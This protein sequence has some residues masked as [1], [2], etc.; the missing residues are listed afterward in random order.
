MTS[1]LLTALVLLFSLAAGAAVGVWS[2]DP[3][4]DRLA[5]RQQAQIGPWRVDMSLASQEAGPY[6]RAYTAREAIWA[7]SKEDALYLLALDDSEGRPL[8]PRCSYTISG[9]RPR[10][11]WWSLTAY[12]DGRFIPNPE[13]RYSY[14]ASTIGDGLGEDRWRVTVG[15]ERTSSDHLPT[16]PDGGELS[17]MLR[18][19]KTPADMILTADDAA[20]PRIVRQRC[21]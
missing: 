7:M 12:Q 19:Y 21:A 18:L 17:L 4:L 10:A 11:V 2:V 1:K 15:P 20:L 9:A 8:S 3:T 16:R 5:A 6:T 13:D 14:S